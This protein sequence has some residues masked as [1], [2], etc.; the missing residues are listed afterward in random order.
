MFVIIPVTK[1]LR[2][3]YLQKADEYLILNII[4]KI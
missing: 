2:K 4:Q 1:I 3:K